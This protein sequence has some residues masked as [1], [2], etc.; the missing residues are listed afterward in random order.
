MPS[1][2]NLL[3]HVKP[4]VLN[5]GFYAGSN[6]CELIPKIKS[7][8]IDVLLVSYHTLGA[9]FKKIYGNKAEAK[10]AGYG[11]EP[12]KKKSKQES[13]FDI[14]FHRFVLDEAH[15]IRSCKTGFFKS[16]LEVK[17]DRKLAL[18]GTPFV[19]RP[20]DIHSLLSFLEVAPL[21][22]KA[23]FKRAVT[24]P[25]QSGHDIGLSR[26]RTTMAH[27]A[28]RRSKALANIKLVG[29]DVQLRSVSFPDNAHKKLYDALFGTVR[30]AFG[31]CM[32]NDEGNV[33]RNYSSIFEKLLRMRQSCCSATLVPA[34]RREAV[35]KAWNE[36]Q[37][38]DSGKKLTPEEGMAL[39]EKLKGTFS[40]EEEE[41]LPE[42]AVCLTEMEEHMCV[43]LRVCSHIYCEA[44][45]SRV[46]AGENKS[47][48]LC[49]KPI[50]KS[51]LVKK[52]AAVDA[53][54]TTSSLMEKAQAVDDEQE[55]SPK[56][57]ALL[58]TIKEMQQEEKGVIFSQ[59][60]SFLNLIGEALKEAGLSF[61]RIDG[62]MS[63][64]K[65]IEAVESFCSDDDD[66]PRFILCSL[67]AA[68]T[69]INLTRG[70][71]AFMMD[72]WW[73]QAVENQA[74]K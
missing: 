33:M 44:C 9:E 69:G 2:G 47:C 28:L 18:T 32:E 49:R 13:L 54:Q 8:K 20:D 11:E 63:A 57:L 35:I 53:S 42:C 66:S 22:D 37:N 4:G 68:G 55:Q 1:R 38:R 39:L 58:E 60:T 59:F 3:Q 71:W 67:H 56:I 45:I 34:K 21:A 7:G 62:S 31:A 19:N 72:C 25:I 64:S 61:T 65:R 41:Q 30:A 29:K 14:T 70:S 17:A 43:I 12:I 73:N 40:Q 24:I 46:V 15:T 36:L 26:L 5:V 10:N 6:R 50:H 23:I 27:I 74:S 52:K 16:C 48:P 51:D